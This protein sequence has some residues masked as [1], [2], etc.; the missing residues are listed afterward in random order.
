MFSD[1]PSI[2]LSWTTPCP[3]A[4]VLS[5][6]ISRWELVLENSSSDVISHTH[7][8]APTANPAAAQPWRLSFQGLDAAAGG[9]GGLILMKAQGLRWAIL[10]SVGGRYFLPED[11]IRSRKDVTRHYIYNRTSIGERPCHGPHLIRCGGG[12][13]P[14][15]H[16][17]LL[18][19]D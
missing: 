11:G 15:S 14:L 3:R 9:L 13:A 17:F 5:E 18:Y 19:V 7:G 6:H 4:G 12:E 10:S 2:P 1:Q 16:G 8:D